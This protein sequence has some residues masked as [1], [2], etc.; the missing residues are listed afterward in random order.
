M[1]TASARRLTG[2]FELPGLISANSNW[3][4]SPLTLLVNQNVVM[5]QTPNGTVIIG[6]FNQS[7]QNNGG[8]LS[9]TSGGGQPLVLNVP[10]GALQPFILMRNWS[11]NNLSITNISPNQ[12]TPIWIAAFGPGIPGQYPLSLPVG[13]PVP[14]AP[15]QSAQGNA[16]PQWMQLNMLSNSPALT[17]FAF[18]G[19]PLDPTGNNGYVVA[20][21]ASQNT[22][23]GT[24][25][26]P[27]PGYYA[28]ITSNAL[29]Y[30]FNW[31]SSLVYV[32][33]MSP[34]TGSGAQVTMRAL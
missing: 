30:S 16:L 19:G 12:N 5:P 31:G 13:T 14:L 7:Q 22:G 17:I 18:I 8:V 25:V 11:A 28:T 24:G 2:E 10:A 29:P 1:S 15:A 26:Q 32:V 3:D 6:Y 27:P 34:A 4:G 23:P 33:N 21:N 9:I 20:V